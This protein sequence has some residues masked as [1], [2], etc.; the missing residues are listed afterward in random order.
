MVQPQKAVL[1]KHCRQ[2]VQSL[3]GRS[4]ALNDYAAPSDDGGSDDDAADLQQLT[5]IAQRLIAQLQARDQ[6][7]QRG[8]LG[9]VCPKPS[10]DGGRQQLS[11]GSDLLS[12]VSDGRL[13]DVERLIDEGADLEY[14]NSVMFDHKLDGDSRSVGRIQTYPKTKDVEY[15]PLILAA[16][17]GHPDIARL[18]L[19]NGARNAQDQSSKIQKLRHQSMLTPDYPQNGTSAIDWALWAYHPDIARMIASELVARLISAA[20]DGRLSDVVALIIEDADVNGRMVGFKGHTCC[21]QTHYPTTTMLCCA[22]AAHVC[23]FS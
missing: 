20:E 10:P 17:S 1:R 21:M 14:R 12:A 9:H 6:H 11:I 4:L 19:D 13:S 23:T 22:L 2:T 15:T 5:A 8:R 16:K 3:R 18:L 7:A